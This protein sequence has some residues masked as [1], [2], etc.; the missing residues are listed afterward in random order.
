MET[1][2]FVPQGPIGLL[3]MPGVFMPLW[4]RKYRSG[5]WPLY[6][7]VVLRIFLKGFISKPEMP[8]L[9][10]YYSVLASQRMLGEATIALAF[11]FPD[12]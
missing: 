7:A 3:E 9:T 6:L 11:V 4:R 8:C 12:T 5:S 2:R 1:G 10:A